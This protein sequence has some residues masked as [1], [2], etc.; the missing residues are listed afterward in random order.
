MTKLRSPS[1]I[2]RDIE[3]LQKEL[4]N[5]ERIIPKMKHKDKPMYAELCL[6]VMSL[7]E[8]CYLEDLTLDDIDPDVKDSIVKRAVESFY[9]TLKIVER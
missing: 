3:S 4:K 9:G 5:S 7:V 1:E 6:S 8:K 2:R